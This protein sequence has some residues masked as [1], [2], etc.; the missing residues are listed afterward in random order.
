[1]QAR[2]WV[3][4]GSKS[5]AACVGAL[6]EVELGGDLG[7]GGDAG[8]GVERGCEDLVE[9]LH[10][11]GLG[12]VGDEGGGA[13]GFEQAIGAE[14][15]G[16]GV[17]GAL[18]GE[19]ANAAADADALGGG[20]DDAF[21]HAEGGGG[22]GL[23]VEIGELSAGGKRFAEAALEQALG[24]AEVGQEVTLVVRGVGMR[25]VWSGCH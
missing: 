19:D 14:V 24:E 21:V 15:V 25:K 1:M 2:T 22:D 7:V 23:E 9:A 13:C 11:L 18:A 12:A 5:R 17:A 3:M 6:D 8:D 4:R 20:L 16:V 10:A